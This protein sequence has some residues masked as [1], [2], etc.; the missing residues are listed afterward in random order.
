MS[1]PSVADI[2]KGR[3]S[4]GSTLLPVFLA[5]VSSVTIRLNLA[6]RPFTNRTLPWAVTGFLLLVSMVAFVFIIRATGQANSQSVALQNEI[7]TLKQEQDALSEKAQAVKSSLAPEQYTALRAAHELVDRKQFSWTRL[8]ADLEAALPGTVRVTRI[9]VRDI[10][11]TSDRTIAELD[12]TVIAKSST[13]ITDMLA[14]MDRAGVFQAE[15]RSQDLQTG[16]GESGTEYEL[17]V[18]YRPR[19]GAPA[20]DTQLTSVATLGDQKSGEAR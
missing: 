18:L 20:A 12:L 7:R 1:R 4:S 17:Y 15:L 13:T 6:S 11:A 8:F 3:V 5:G 2:S 14:D 9:S 19:L 10:A 16:R